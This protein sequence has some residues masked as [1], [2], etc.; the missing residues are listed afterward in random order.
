MNEKIEQMKAQTITFWTSK[1]KK[2]KGFF[3]GSVIVVLLLIVM[4]LFFTLRT[5]YAPLYSNLSV[6]ETGQIKETLDSRGIAN[7]INENG[8][9]IY[10]QETSLMM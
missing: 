10:V 9:A 5:N 6:E 7:T 4:L 1:T 3:I 2:Q 8:T